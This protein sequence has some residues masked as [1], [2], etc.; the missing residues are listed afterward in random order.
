M[1]NEIWLS[2]FDIYRSGHEAQAHIDPRIPVSRNTESRS[3]HASDAARAKDISDI[4]R[5]RRQQREAEYQAEQ[6]KTTKET[7]IIERFKTVMTLIFAV[8]LLQVLDHTNTGNKKCDR[9]IGIDAGDGTKDNS[10]LLVLL[11]YL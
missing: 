10:I 8:E 6:E 11:R 3:I 7:L 2:D 1:Q 5:Q 4:R 9:G